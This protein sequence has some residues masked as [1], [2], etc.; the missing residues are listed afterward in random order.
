MIS[1]A[2]AVN[3]HCPRV[4]ITGSRWAQAVV[5]SSLMV[6]TP[7]LAHANPNCT[8]ELAT[9]TYSVLTAFGRRFKAQSLRANLWPEFH[10]A[11]MQ[12]GVCEDGALGE[13]Y[14]DLSIGMLRDRWE[15]AQAFNPLQS[16][17]TFRRFVIRHLDSTVKLEDL[18]SVRSKAKHRYGS[19]SASFCREVAR[20]CKLA[21]SDINQPLDK[22]PD[23]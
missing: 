23:Q 10:T 22:R 12:Y 20:A 15:D 6:L 18:R 8:R 2:S 9:S 17:G 19:H 13:M 1:L 7:R 5:M 21:I 4:G 16:E 3:R 14:S 11:V